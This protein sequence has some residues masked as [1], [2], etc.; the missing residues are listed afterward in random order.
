VGDCDAVTAS[1]A[2]DVDIAPTDDRAE[3][4]RGFLPHLSSLLAKVAPTP[5]SSLA[6]TCCTKLSLDA[7]VVHPS[8]VPERFA[9]S[10]PAHDLDHARVFRSLVDERVKPAPPDVAFGLRERTHS[11]EERWET[12][13][14]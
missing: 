3:L 11:R 7:A 9:S 6:L 12:L 14:E 8:R 5:A 1:Y 13:S 2:N 10:G 4:T